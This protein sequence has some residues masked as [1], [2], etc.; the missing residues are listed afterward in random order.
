MSGY[1]AYKENT[2]IYTSWL[3][4]TAANHESEMITSRP[5]DAVEARAAK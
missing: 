4:A 1:L 5:I 2:G 3:C